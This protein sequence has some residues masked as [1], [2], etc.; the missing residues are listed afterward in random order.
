LVVVSLLGWR[1]FYVCLWSDYNVGCYRLGVSIPFV[2]R[3]G[4]LFLCLG[5]AAIAG[6]GNWFQF[7]TVGE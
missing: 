7:Q 6:L 1:F 4:G 3:F 2:G 5:G